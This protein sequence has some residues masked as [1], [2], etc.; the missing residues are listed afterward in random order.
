MLLELP[1][2]ICEYILSLIKI[3]YKVKYGTILDDGEQTYSIFY[4]NTDILRLVCKQF[5]I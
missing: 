2:N 3:E 5:N 1:N 4:K